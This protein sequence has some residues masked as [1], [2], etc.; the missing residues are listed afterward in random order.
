MAQ[1][2]P[3][4]LIFEHNPAAAA[5]P[6]DISP[7]TRYPALFASPRQG[8][9]V[10]YDAALNQR[11]AKLLDKYSDKDA[12]VPPAV[13]AA[14]AMSDMVAKHPVSD[15]SSLSARM[16]TTFWYPAEEAMNHGFG[17]GFPGQWREIPKSRGGQ[18][19]GWMFDSKTTE[20]TRAL[21]DTQLLTEWPPAEIYDKELVDAKIDKETKVDELVR[22]CGEEGGLMVVVKDERDADGHVV[23]R[24]RVVDEGGHT[25]PGLDYWAH[26]LARL[27]ESL[28]LHVTNTIIATSYQSWIPIKHDRDDENNSILRMGNPIPREGAS[29]NL[30][31]GD[32]TPMQLVVSIKTDGLSPSARAFTPVPI[33]SASAVVSNDDEREAVVFGKGIEIDNR[34]RRNNT[35]RAHTPSAS[36]ME[37]FQ[38]LN[39]SVPSNARPARFQVNLQMRPHLRALHRFWQGNL[40]S[41][42]F[43]GFVSASHFPESSGE[44]IIFTSSG[45][46]VHARVTLGMYASS[47]RLWDAY[48]GYIDGV[49]VRAIKVIAKVSHPATFDDIG[50]TSD[51][52]YE[53]G[54]AASNSCKN[55]SAMYSGPLSSLQGDVVPLRYASL[56]GFMN[57]QQM[58]YAMSKV[59]IEVLEDVGEP[60]NAKVCLEDLPLTDKLAIRDLY[61]RLHAVRVLHND[62]ETRHIRR[63]PDGRFAL[64]DFEGS[65]KVRDGAK[66]DA[67]LDFEAREVE[68]LL[69]WTDDDTDDDDRGED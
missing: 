24:V 45:S 61:R 67:A 68:G 65:R 43:R 23:S 21:G 56:V 54:E 58:Y 6:P 25:R 19:N 5:P 42:D 13:L 9:R 34:Q 57:A 36:A 38:E 59:Y 14:E 48:D 32:M 29:G 11:L 52:V 4:P 44:T 49:G 40:D 18:E 2:V 30:E 66:G 27:W 35:P 50:G 55:E 37:M 8:F 22:L 28:Q 33:C 41:G 64:I 10:I 53:S 60:A 26:G 39:N 12:P 15:H 46:A 47:G 20:G 51:S 62:V 3:P 7:S 17:R 16:A 63:R 1:H 31:V 69:G